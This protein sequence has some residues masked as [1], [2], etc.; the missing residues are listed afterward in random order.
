MADIQYFSH[1]LIEE[2]NTDSSCDSDE[3]EDGKKERIG[4]YDYI[5]SIGKIKFEDE[6][7]EQ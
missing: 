7:Q 2:H 6:S 4:L 1:T 5:D 3:G